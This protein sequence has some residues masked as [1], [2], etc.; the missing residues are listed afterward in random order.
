[1]VKN[2]PH[3]CPKKL[4]IIGA[5]TRVVSDF[6]PATVSLPD[7]Y[8]IAG[9]FATSARTILASAALFDVEPLAAL[10]R[11]TLATAEM[12]YIAVPETSMYS[13]LSALKPYDVSR[14]DLIVDTPALAVPTNDVYGRWRSVAV[15]EDSVFLPWL[16]TVRRA[17]SGSIG[18]LQR[19]YF[20]HS[21]FRYHGVALAKA[22]LAT[23]G[24]AA[25][26]SRAY[27]LWN[28]LR[29]ISHGIVV[30]VREPRDYA[31]GRFYLQCTYGCISDRKGAKCQPI[32]LLKSNGYCTGFRIG[33]T[34][35]DLSAEES[36]LAGKIAGNDTVVTRMLDFKRVG[37]RRFLIA[38]SNGERTWTLADGLDDAAIAATR[39]WR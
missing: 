11:D 9:I 31:R 7:R 22:L 3:D 16:E 17:T 32:E 19:A 12:I 27:K 18:R 36:M 4:I 10:T 33:E 26:I 21:A 29:M 25:P 1:L 35:T 28:T 8:C 30:S 20:K 13:V 14:I 24:A 6:V 39:L 5:G 34:E 15:A 2:H 37:L 23:D 38:H